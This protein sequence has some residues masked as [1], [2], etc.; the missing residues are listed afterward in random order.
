MIHITTFCGGYDNNFSYLVY[1]E[2]SPEAILI[3]TALDPQ[4]ILDFAVMNGLTIKYAVVMHSHF[5]HTIKLKEYRKNNILLVGSSQLPFPVDKNV[6][7]NDTIL[8]G[9]TTIRVI[10]APGHTPDCI[11]LYLHGKLFTTDVL[12]IDSCGRCDLPSGD[13]KQ[14]YETLYTKILTLPDD[15]VIY[16][17]HD[18]GP[19]PYDTLGNQKRTNLFLK[20]R[21]KEEFLTGGMIS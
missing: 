6:N 19:V 9:D 13:L 12:F 5:D 1:D 18:Y 2:D 20:A 4:E 17:G 8:L 7:D 3:D 16:P 21:S 15:T 10:S 14:M 11:L